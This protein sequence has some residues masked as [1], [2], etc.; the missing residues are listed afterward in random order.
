MLSHPSEM[1]LPSLVLLANRNKEHLVF[2]GGP[3]IIPR[4]VIK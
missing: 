4:V 2:L 3:E 1:I